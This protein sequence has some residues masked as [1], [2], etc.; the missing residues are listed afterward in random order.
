MEGLLPWVLGTSTL[1]SGLGRRRSGFPV[2]KSECFPLVVWLP[3]RRETLPSGMIVP[4]S[5]NVAQFASSRAWSI[6]KSPPTHTLPPPHIPPQA[7]SLTSSPSIPS[8]H[9]P[10]P[11][12]PEHL[13]CFQCLFSKTALSDSKY[14]E[15]PVPAKLWTLLSGD[16]KETQ[17]SRSWISHNTKDTKGHLLF[18]LFI[19]FHV[20]FFPKQSV[21][22]EQA[23]A[24]HFI[25][26]MSQNKCNSTFSPA[27]FLELLCLFFGFVFLCVWVWE[28]VCPRVVL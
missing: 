1:L 7:P 25:D 17:E 12:K 15:D 20:F 4:S 10:Q 22:P 21:S 24:S 16:D 23:A 11:P 18:W 14:E 28:F 9:P 8:Q 6:L 27:T 2:Q 26:I 3:L 19:Y 13:L 5:S